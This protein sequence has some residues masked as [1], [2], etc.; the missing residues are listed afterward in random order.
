MNAALAI[1]IDEYNKIDSEA[2][3][4]TSFRTF[5]ARVK[6]KIIEDSDKFYVMSKEM[7]DL[8]N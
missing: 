8:S 3:H 7:A 4:L 5:K 1:A 2:R 6:L